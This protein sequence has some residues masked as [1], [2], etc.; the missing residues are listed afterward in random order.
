M[1][2]GRSLRLEPLALYCAL[3][4]GFP[5]NDTDAELRQI[6]NNETGIIG[7]AE[8]EKHFARGVVIHVSSEANLL[9]VAV[10]FAKDDKMLVKS[11]L[12]D[13]SVS[14][15]STEQAKDWQSRDPDIW[16]VVAAPWVLVQERL[17]GA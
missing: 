9:D 3:F 16:G 8:I 6:L 14:A 2:F 17:E 7:W 15:L 10:G 13:G 5:M 1:V 12:N 4:D 11:W